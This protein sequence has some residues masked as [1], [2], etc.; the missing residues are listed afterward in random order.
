MIDGTGSEQDTAGCV[1]LPAAQLAN[2][3]SLSFSKVRTLKDFKP[4][5]CFTCSDGDVSHNLLPFGFQ[6]GGEG[7]DLQVTTPCPDKSFGKR[8]SFS[9]PYGS[10]FQPELSQT[11][12]PPGFDNLKD[13]RS[14]GRM[15]SVTLSW[16]RNAQ[17]NH[18]IDFTYVNQAR[19]IH[20]RNTTYCSA[21]CEIT[22]HK[23]N[24]ALQQRKDCL[25]P[26]CYWIQIRLANIHTSF[27]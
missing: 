22:F 20:H 14:P 17:K 12:N 5:T 7:N 6:T 3:H 27:I 15:K 18:G 19:T 1:C 10:P 16:C 9:M 23:K 2:T 21:N 13:C 24:E 8:I 4:N 25:C 26:S 11:P